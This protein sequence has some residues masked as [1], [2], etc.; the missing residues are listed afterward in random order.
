MDQT[1][2]GWWREE[3]SLLWQQVKKISLKTTQRKIE[4]ANAARDKAISLG[5]ND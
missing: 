2:S 3:F 5:K 1:L 4:Y